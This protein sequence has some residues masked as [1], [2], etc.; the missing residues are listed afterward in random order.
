MRLEQYI[1]KQRDRLSLMFSEQ[2]GDVWLSPRSSSDTLQDPST[3]ELNPG[4]ES[5]RSRISNLIDT[6]RPEIAL[7]LVHKALDR[8]SENTID[9]VIA[10]AKTT[11][12]ELL[13]AGYGIQANL[14]GHILTDYGCPPEERFAAAPGM[15][16]PERTAPAQTMDIGLPVLR[17]HSRMS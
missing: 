5:L 8:A 9:E 14:L 4:R 2:A 7:A 16:S 10:I 15:K 17:L 1:Q 6:G 13:D 12:D 3:L 11:Y